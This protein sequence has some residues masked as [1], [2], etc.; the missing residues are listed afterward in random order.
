MNYFE[1]IIGYEA[2]KN[3]LNIIIDCINNREKYDAL[4]VK[5]P[6][7]LLLH[8]EAGLGKTITAEAF[9]NSANRN[10]YIIRK[11]KHNGDFINEL[12]NTL[13]EA[14]ENQPSIILLDDIDKYANND[15]NHRNA[16]EFIVVQSFIDGI[17]DQDVFVV[18]TA[19]RVDSLPE[20]LIRNG[21]FDNVIEFH[22]PTTADS[23][24]IIEHYLKNKK[25]DSNLDFNEIAKIL[26]GCSCSVLENV[27]NQA[28]LYAGYKNHASI[29][30]EDIIDASLRVIYNDVKDLSDKTEAELV[31][32]A[33]H[34]AGHAMVAE[35]LAPGSVNLVSIS[36]YFGS[37]GGV[38][39]IDIPDDY[40]ISYER[41][42]NRVRELLAG[43][44]ATSLL[45]NK[46]DVG[47][48]SDYGRAVRILRRFCSDYNL[49]RINA[50]G[51]NLYSNEA[52]LACE[53][54]ISDMIE[55]YKEDDKKILTENMDSL[56]RIA[57]ALKTKTT[58]RSSEIQ[59]L[60]NC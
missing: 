20:S 60:I 23:A 46:I 51:C 21:R 35:A 55:K 32:A 44:V 10:R 50:N 4:G 37:T 15:E 40:W 33:I 36:N 1:N 27:M 8:G 2:I 56:K 34:E 43:S 6:R 28:G 9:I 11:N 14:C 29:T 31:A 41:M 22:N 57:D 12:S 25:V 54:W 5:I 7:N 19:N 16:D 30:I 48:S 49:L 18:A 38:T 24:L 13:N 58:L 26:G 17:K 53:K 47:A 52:L 42:E 3:E 39:S 59:K 45:S